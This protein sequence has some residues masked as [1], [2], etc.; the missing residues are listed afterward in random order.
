MFRVL[1]RAAKIISKT[2][3]KDDDGQQDSSMSN[4]ELELH[5]KTTKRN[6]QYQSMA[7]NLIWYI[8]YQLTHKKAPPCVGFELQTLDKKEKYT[9]FYNQTKENASLQKKITS[10]KKDLLTEIRIKFKKDFDSL[11]DLEFLKLVKIEQAKVDLLNATAEIEY[12]KLTPELKTITYQKPT[13]KQKNPSTILSL[14]ANIR[15]LEKT[16]PVYTFDM[17]NSIYKNMDQLVSY[18]KRLYDSLD[19]KKS[20]C[21]MEKNSTK[22]AGSAAVLDD[23][24]K[25]YKIEVKFLGAILL[26]LDLEVV[27]HKVVKDLSV[28][29]YPLPTK[30]LL[31]L[32]AERLGKSCCNSVEFPA[33]LAK[34]D[35]DIKEAKYESVAK[36][37]HAWAVYVKYR[38]L[39]EDNQITLPKPKDLSDFKTYSKNIHAIHGYVSRYPLTLNLETSD[40]GYGCLQYITFTQNSQIKI[41]DAITVPNKT[42]KTMSWKDRLD[43]FKSFTSKYNVGDFNVIKVEEVPYINIQ[44]STLNRGDEYFYIRTAGIGDGTLFVHTLNKKR[45]GNSSHIR[46]PKITTE[47]LKM[48]HVKTVTQQVSPIQQVSVSDCIMTH[49]DKPYQL[50]SLLVNN[51]IC[52]PICDNF[53]TFTPKIELME[54]D[55]EYAD[56]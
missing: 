14:L 24:V 13:N 6:S 22:N 30:S 53:G 45:P 9:D 5:S 42:L 41:F 38:R 16:E 36:Q 46:Y 34:I 28:A 4:K 37:L 51:L 43:T 15:C 35:G 21:I 50:D 17:V 26:E 7:L 12:A 27:M 23:E 39:K 56:F 8:A 25:N 49:Y 10:L 29:Y 44:Y 2:L 1:K 11:D 32:V 55:N 3:Q 40:T 52:T 18:F 48:V 19:N 33:E 47:H 54:E 31:K 20:G